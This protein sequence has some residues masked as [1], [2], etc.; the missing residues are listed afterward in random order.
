MTA[1]EGRE[2]TVRREV[3]ANQWVVQ[4]LLV[5]NESLPQPSTVNGIPV[6][7]P[8]V[9]PWLPGPLRLHRGCT[10]QGAIWLGFLVSWA[11]PTGTLAGARSRTAVTSVC[12]RQTL[13]ERA[14]TLL[15]PMLGVSSLVLTTL[16]D[17]RREE[18]D[19]T[20]P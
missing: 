6:P 16:W 17:C 14:S 11:W 3:W 20:G 18:N 8:R 15:P 12:K 2:G 9:W 7:S 13:S 1:S 10:G 19:R 5:A 4:G